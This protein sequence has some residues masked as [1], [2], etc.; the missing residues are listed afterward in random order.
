VLERLRFLS[1]SGKN[2]DEFV[3]VRVAGLKGQ[4]GTDLNR[5]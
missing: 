5:Q 1:I 4:A 2:L 3:M